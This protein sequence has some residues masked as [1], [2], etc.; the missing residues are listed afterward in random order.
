M[1]KTL[2]MA[3]VTLGG[4]LTL[5]G[6]N[7]MQ[8][9]GQDLQNTGQAIKHAAVQ[10]KADKAISRQVEY[11]IQHYKNLKDQSINVSTSGSTVT[12][13]GHVDHQWQSRAAAS[14]AYRVKGVKRVVNHLQ[15][16]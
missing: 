4:A 15:V 9:A 16:K 11:R 12:L 6:C 8:G 2:L 13:T 5:A 10:S 3:A 1:K 7:T 14:E